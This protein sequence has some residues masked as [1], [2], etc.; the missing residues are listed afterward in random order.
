[1]YHFPAI[2]LQIVIDGQKSAKFKKCHFGQISKFGTLLWEKYCRYP[3]ILH[4]CH[5]PIHSEA[6]QAKNSHMVYHTF[7]LEG[8]K[9]PKIRT[10]D[11]KY[12]F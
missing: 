1:M 7:E 12:F 9:N 8:L 5:T 11:P 10:F 2:M 6:S 3:V 4:I